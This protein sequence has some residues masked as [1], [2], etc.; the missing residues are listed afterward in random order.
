MNRQA[1][2][3]MARQKAT[4]QDRAEAMRQRRAVT[5]ER[6][7]RVPPREFLKQVRQE[8]RKVNWPTRRELGAYT[9]VVLAAVVVLTGLVFALDLGFSKVVLRLF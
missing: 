5:T 6:K 4:T 9:T 1:K 8:L 7:R 3:M 2:R